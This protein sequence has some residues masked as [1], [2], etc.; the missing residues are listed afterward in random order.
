M[1]ANRKFCQ[2]VISLA[3]QARK[4]ISI[5]QL[6]SNST[7]LFEQMM[8]NH[9]DSEDKETRSMSIIYAGMISSFMS[10]LYIIWEENIQTPE[11]LSEALLRN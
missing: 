10:L 9:R 8:N 2:D 5:D 1:I 11:E 4:L 7:I 3:W 6:E